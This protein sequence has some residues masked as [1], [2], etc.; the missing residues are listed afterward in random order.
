MKKL[1]I[2][3]SEEEYKLLVEYCL[4]TSRTQNDV[5]RELIRNLKKS[6]PSRTGL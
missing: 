4:E 2:R 6:R 5:L 3:C 1:T